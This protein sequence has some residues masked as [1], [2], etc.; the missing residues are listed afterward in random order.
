[1]KKEDLSFETF[2]I[3]FFSSHERFER[4]REDESIIII[5]IIIIIIASSS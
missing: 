4:E 5:I 1:M 3:P 2:G